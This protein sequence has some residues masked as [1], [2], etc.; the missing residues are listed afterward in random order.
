MAANH[1]VFGVPCPIC[2][3]EVGQP[4][5]YGEVEGTH[6][7]RI[8]AAV[9][10]GKL[11]LV[12]SLNLPFPVIAP[13]ELDEDANRRAFIRQIV[14][15]GANPVVHTVTNSEGRTPTKD[16]VRRGDY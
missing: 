7:K 1:A 10:A 9:K 2:E 5:T 3:V 14:A 15:D 8:A 6:A 12:E 16:D 4:C 13:P 11:G